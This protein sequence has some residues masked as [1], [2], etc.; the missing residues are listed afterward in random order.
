MLLEMSYLPVKLRHKMDRRQKAKIQLEA[1]FKSAELK[2]QIENE[3]DSCEPD[4]GLMMNMSAEAHFKVPKYKP[5]VP[6]RPEPAPIAAATAVPVMPNAPVQPPLVPRGTSEED[7]ID[8]LDNDDELFIELNL[9]PDQEERV[10]GR[11]TRI[12]SETSSS[13]SQ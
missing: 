11:F 3:I 8:V 5:V 12:R 9:T 4:A 7:P 1:N 6:L 2:D 13:F 10:R